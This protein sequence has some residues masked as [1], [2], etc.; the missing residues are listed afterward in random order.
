M[1]RFSFTCLRRACGA[2]APSDVVTSI[3]GTLQRRALR[4]HPTSSSTRK[5]RLLDQI[6]LC[7]M[8]GAPEFR[9][10][11]PRLPSSAG[12][13]RVLGEFL[14][15]GWAIVLDDGILQAD[16]VVI[17]G[18]RLGWGGVDLSS[19]VDGD[20]FPSPQTQLYSAVEFASNT[21][22]TTLAPTS[23]RGQS[24]SRA[25]SGSSPQRDLHATRERTVVQLQYSRNRTWRNIEHDPHR[26]PVARI[27]IR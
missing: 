15:G 3:T 6:G 11:D 20:D 23:H 16:V 25:T 9:A 26:N 27:D 18:Q 17:I 1:R 5:V 12:L 2:W 7:R 10:D 14:P 22:M 4:P 21:P 13:P 24:R 19:L 8:G